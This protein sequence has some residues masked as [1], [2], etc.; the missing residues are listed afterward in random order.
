MSSTTTNLKAVIWESN[1]SLPESM[2]GR[3][4]NPINGEHATTWGQAVEAR[5]L[6]QPEPFINVH[7]PYGSFDDPIISFNTNTNNIKLW[8]YYD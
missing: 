5:I 4:K 2:L 7:F 1:Q 3:F 8:Y 6:K